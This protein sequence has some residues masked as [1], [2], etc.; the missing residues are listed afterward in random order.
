MSVTGDDE[1]ISVNCLVRLT[2]CSAVGAAQ[3]LFVK[4]ILVTH[5]EIAGLLG[6]SC[7]GPSEHLIF[8]ILFEKKNIFLHRNNF[9]QGYIHYTKKVKDILKF[10]RCFVLFC[11]LAFSI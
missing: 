10:S 5:T 8:F 2:I 11:E 1:I 7:K 3:Y 9:L 6:G 4:I